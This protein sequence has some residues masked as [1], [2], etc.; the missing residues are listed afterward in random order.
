MFMSRSGRWRTCALVD[1]SFPNDER[2]QRIPSGRRTRAL[3]VW[4]VAL[5]YARRHELDGFCPMESLHGFANDEVIQDLVDV[6]LFARGEED[7]LSGVIVVDYAECN[8]TNAKRHVTID[9]TGY[10]DPNVARGHG[11]VTASDVG[12]VTSSL[13]T[14]SG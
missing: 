12:A 8:G 9:V 2:L 11:A 4:M 6:G 1:A 10:S 7:G 13:C 3:G 14:A 5:C